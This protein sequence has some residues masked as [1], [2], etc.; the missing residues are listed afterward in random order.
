MFA[1]FILP[2]SS[3]LKRP[4]GAWQARFQGF[5]AQRCAMLTPGDKGDTWRYIILHLVGGLVAVSYFPI[6]WE[7]SSQLTFIFFRG[8]QTTNQTLFR[9]RGYPSDCLNSLKFEIDDLTEEY[10]LVACHDWYRM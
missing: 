8:V 10:V 9:N 7:S 2:A 1:L 6:Y 4:H 5:Q 3:N